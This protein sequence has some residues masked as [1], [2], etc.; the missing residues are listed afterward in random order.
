LATASGN[1][2]WT[3]FAHE[4][5]VGVRGYGRDM[6]EAFAN[7]ARAL[8]AVLVPPGSI[9]RQRRIEVQCSAADPE[10]LFVDWLNAVIFS[11]AT[12]RMLFGD[13]R[14]TIAKDTLR[15][16]LWGEPVEPARHEPAV[17][18]K[19]ATLTALRV[20]QEPDGRWLAQCVVD[21]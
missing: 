17:E 6:A 5:D 10:I 11:M 13:F 15:A 14:V 16:E 3:H 4:G 9:R 20:A 8:S 18:P 19:G 7:A 1:A 21:V 2:D 12:E